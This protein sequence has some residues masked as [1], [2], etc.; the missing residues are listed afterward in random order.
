[1]FVELEQSRSMAT[2]AAMMAG[3][4]DAMERERAISA[5]KLQIGRSA[6]VIG[7]QSIQL[8]GGI[9]MTMEYSVGHYFKRTTM[10]NAQFGDADHHLTRVAALGGLVANNRA[11]HP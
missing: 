5:A 7:H 2:Y 10:I 6:K 3:R 4:A 1:M 8:H 11:E 9:G